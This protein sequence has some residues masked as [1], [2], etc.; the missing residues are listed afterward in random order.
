VSAK[1]FSC[2]PSGTI[3]IPAGG[4]VAA[5]RADPSGASRTSTLDARSGASTDSD[6]DR[7]AVVQMD[8]RPAQ[9]SRPSR[10][11][12]SPAPAAS[13]RP[14]SRRRRCTGRRWASTPASC[15]TNAAGSTAAHSQSYLTSLP[16]ASGRAAFHPL[17]R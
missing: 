3:R 10:S 8:R 7:A 12:R 2:S 5:P 13:A 14:A 6:I 1:S 9:T 16:P 15:D 17:P 11:N 4:D